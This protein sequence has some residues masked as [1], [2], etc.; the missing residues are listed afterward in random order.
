M[1]CEC[2]FSVH[3]YIRARHYLYQYTDA[4]SVEALRGQW[5]SRQPL[6]DLY[7]PVVAEEHLRPYI[8]D[9]GF[10]W[11]TPEDTHN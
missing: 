1:L 7:I 6:N 11:Y 4:G 10:Q 8:E 9:M 5:W 3:R 2:V